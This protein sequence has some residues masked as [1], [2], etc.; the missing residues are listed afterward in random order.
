MMR[1][2]SAGYSSSIGAIIEDELD[3]WHRSSTV[4]TVSGTRPSPISLRPDTVEE[5]GWSQKATGE[6]EDPSLR[7]T[8]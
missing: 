8:R 4:Q 7:P 5:S 3:P 6:L 2:H 1:A